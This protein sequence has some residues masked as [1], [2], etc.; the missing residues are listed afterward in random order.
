MPNLRLIC[1]VAS[2]IWITSMSINVI[3]TCNMKY[4]VCIN[5]RTMLNQKF[6]KHSACTEILTNLEVMH[7][8]VTVWFCFSSGRLLSDM[9]LVIKAAKA[10][11]W[12]S[13]ADIANEILPCFSS[14]K[15][16]ELQVCPHWIWTE[17]LIR[18]R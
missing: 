7:A 11:L 5:T 9:I 4:C 3:V 2:H 18:Q 15:K 6:S 13:T 8:L 12:N 17:G 10:D 1:L 14:T 16:Q